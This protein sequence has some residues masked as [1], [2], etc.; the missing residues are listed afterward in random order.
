MIGSHCACSL[1]CGYFPSLDSFQVVYMF[2]YANLV[3][4]FQDSG[5]TLLFKTQIPSAEQMLQTIVS[6]QFDSIW[7]CDFEYY[8]ICLSVSAHFS[9]WGLLHLWCDSADPGLHSGE[10]VLHK[11]HAMLFESVELGRRPLFLTLPRQ[12]FTLEWLLLLIVSKIISKSSGKALMQVLHLFTVLPSLQLCSLFWFLMCRCQCEK[13]LMLPDHYAIIAHK[14]TWDGKKHGHDDFATMTSEETICHILKFS[15]FSCM[16]ACVNVCFESWCPVPCPCDLLSSW[17]W[18]DNVTWLH[19][20]VLMASDSVL[21]V[22][23]F[24]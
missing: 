7:M 10:A 9:L 14:M 4:S 19:Q 8:R 22:S 18:L 21:W 2:H 6:W 1:I 12:G 5:Q 17:P 15:F 13:W 24:S 23:V 16:F 20:H 3:S 11:T